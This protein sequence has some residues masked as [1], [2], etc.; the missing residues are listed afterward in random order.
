MDNSL[1]TSLPA[2][3]AE[4]KKAYLDAIEA[5][6]KEQFNK[7]PFEGSWTAGQASE[8]ATKSLKGIAQT[9]SGKTEN[10][11]RDPGQYVP[12][13]KKQFLDFT[14]KMK[15]PDFLIPSNGPHDKSNALETARK[16]F[17]RIAEANATFDLTATC[18]D[19]Q[20]PGTGPMTRL[21]WLHF[22]LSHTKRHTH[23]LK[24]IN[25]KL[26]NP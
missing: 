1:I 10:T 2:D 3:I 26:I 22:V 16:A 18:L 24:N 21:E 25:A 8:H 6:D 19:F 5:V 20:F 15:S 17:D 4:T 23:Q 9:L 7:I 14:I 12:D 13:L 11:D